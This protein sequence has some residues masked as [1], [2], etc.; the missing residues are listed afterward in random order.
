MARQRETL[1]GTNYVLRPIYEDVLDDLGDPPLGFPDECKFRW[2]TKLAV[3]TPQSSSGR[4]I[5]VGESVEIDTTSL[6]DDV[7]VIRM[8]DKLADSDSDSEDVETQ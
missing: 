7:V 5:Y 1:H 6:G 8:P 2:P 3:L 4:Y